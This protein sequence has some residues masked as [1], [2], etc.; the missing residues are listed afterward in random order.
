MKL[1]LVIFLSFLI[2]LSCGDANLQEENKPQIKDSIYYKPVKPSI[3]YSESDSVWIIFRE[4]LLTKNID[5]LSML[6]KFPLKIK[7]TL[8]SYPIHYVNQNEFTDFINV[9]LK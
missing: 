4:K 3:I 2:I 9:F 5:S 1:N 8:D 6:I 7:G